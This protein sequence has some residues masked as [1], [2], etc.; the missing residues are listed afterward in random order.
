ME[1]FFF[2]KKFFFL[3]LGEPVGYTTQFRG[4]G[5][6]REQRGNATREREGSGGCIPGGRGSGD[7]QN[8]KVVALP[9]CPC[10][11][12]LPLQFLM[13]LHP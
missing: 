11:F 12:T 10:N 2:T 1:N 13:P 9:L 7:S 5:D 6:P 8:V 3:I 4:E